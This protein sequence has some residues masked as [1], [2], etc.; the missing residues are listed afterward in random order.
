MSQVTEAW[1]FRLCIVADLA[2]PQRV[3]INFAQQ[4]FPFTFM[5]PC[6]QWGRSAMSC[7]N[8]NSLIS[9]RVLFVLTLKRLIIKRLAC[10][11]NCIYTL[12]STS[13]KNSGTNSSFSRKLHYDSGTCVLR[14]IL[15][16]PYPESSSHNLI[17]YR[18][19]DGRLQELHS[20]MLESKLRECAFFKS[21]ADALI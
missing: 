1:S 18:F 12:F 7:V 8:S 6:W 4:I 16:K 21:I 15:A 20:R 14:S 19:K 9:I 3:D 2:L 10:W 5:D 17:C 13:R 11:L